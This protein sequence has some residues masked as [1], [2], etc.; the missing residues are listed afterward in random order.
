MLHPP[1]TPDRYAVSDEVSIRDGLMRIVTGVVNAS[2]LETLTGPESMRGHALSC[3]VFSAMVIGG[4]M[5][6]C[7]VANVARHMEAAELSLDKFRGLADRFSVAA[8]VLFAMCTILKNN[9]IRGPAYKK[10]GTK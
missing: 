1:P 3:A 4:L 5:L 7:P 9:S 8:L 2:S 10:V 6:G